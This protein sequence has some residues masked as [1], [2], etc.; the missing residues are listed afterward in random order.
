M[1]CISYH[2]DLT[3]LTELKL[4]TVTTQF[5]PQPVNLSVASKSTFIA[6]GQSA[7]SNNEQE[8]SPFILKI[9]A[10]KSVLCEK[11]FE[12]KWPTQRSRLPGVFKVRR[13]VIVLQILPNPGQ[14]K[15]LSSQRCSEIAVTKMLH[16]SL[17]DL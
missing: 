8:K 12:M 15:L 10:I 9:F 11:Q 13:W 5:T 2:G 1:T 3:I 4:K 6:P 7:F 17:N 16:S 14:T